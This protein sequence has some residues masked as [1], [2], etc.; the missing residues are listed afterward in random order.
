[1]PFAVQVGVVERRRSEDTRVVCFE[2]L[3]KPVSLR[4]GKPAG[5]DVG[6]V[7]VPVESAVSVSVVF[8]GRQ[9]EKASW[10]YHLCCTKLALNSVCTVGGCGSLKSDKKGDKDAGK[11]A[12]PWILLAEALTMPK[13][14]T[15][16]VRW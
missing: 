4:E 9:A 7:C 14:R 10:V 1:M 3:D 12:Q 8:V 13:Y 16:V 6:E 15:A 2:G 11:D 5:G